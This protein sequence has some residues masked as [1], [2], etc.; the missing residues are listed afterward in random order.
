MARWPSLSPPPPRTAWWWPFAAGVATGAAMAGAFLAGR[1]SGAASALPP[2][3]RAW[4]G[5]SRRM[6]AMAETLRE[7]SAFDADAVRSRLD[8]LPGSEGLRLR[9]L[10]DGILE[11][12]G[13]APDAERARAILD[14]L[15]KE[16]GVRAVVNRV[17]TPSSAAPADD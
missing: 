12:V 13:T 10:T 2:L 3:S 8:R 17:W 6:S 14:A 7:P 11:V 15:S 1:R 16:P 9:V 4:E 5:A